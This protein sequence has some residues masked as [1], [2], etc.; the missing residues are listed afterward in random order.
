MTRDVPPYC[1]VHKINE[2]S[3]LN[4]VGLKRA[5]ISPS[6]RKEIKKAFALL[7]NSKLSRVDALAK[8]DAQTWGPHAGK[9]VDA[10]RTPSAKGILTR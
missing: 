4:T 2:L 9:L 6:E 10:V 5:G 3:G 8:A 7:L 1:I